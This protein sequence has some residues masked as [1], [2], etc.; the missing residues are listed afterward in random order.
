MAPSV[1]RRH[2]PVNYAKQLLSAIQSIRQQKQIP[3]FDRISRFLQ[4]YTDI[5]PRRCKEHL[6]N[7]V[8][9]GFIV[10]YTALGV[11]GQRTGLEQ[12]GYRSTQDGDEEEQDDGHDWYCF[13][14]H[15]P[16]EVYECSDCFRVYHQGCTREDT[17]GEAFVCSVCRASKKKNKM[18]KKM[19]NTLLSYTILRLREKTRELHKIGLKANAEDFKRF[20][21]RRM[22]LNRMEQKVQASRY[23]CLEEFHADARTILHNCTLVYGDEKGGMTD[24]AVV[25]VKDC[26]Y[27][28]DEIE[29][30]PNCYYM[31]NA[32]PEDWFSQPCNPPHELVYAKQ[33]GYS[34]WPA[35]VVKDLGGKSDVRFFGGWHQRAVIP[36]EYIKP[37]T[38]DLKAMT[39]KRTAGFTKAVKELKRHQEILEERERELEATNGKG[40]DEEEE[41]EE[42][43]EDEEEMGEQ[44]EEAEGEQE[45]G[46]EKHTEESLEEEEEEVIRKHSP[47]KAVRKKRDSY[48]NRSK[49]SQKRKREDVEDEEEEEDDF[50]NR[51]VTSTSVEKNA[52]KRQRNSAKYNSQ[53]ELHTVTSSMDKVANS[54]P[55]PMTTTASQTLSLS[56]EVASVQTDPMVT[57]TEQDKGSST[58]APASGQQS[59]A[60]DSSAMEE[61]MAEAMAQL[62]RR[63][64]EKFEEDKKDALKELSQRLEEDFGKDKQQAVERTIASMKLEVEKARKQGEENT[65]EQYMEEMKKLAAKH[66]EA[67]SQA[68]KQQ[69]CQSCEKEAIYHCCW[70]TSYCSTKCQQVHWHKEHKRVCRRKRPETSSNH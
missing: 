66:K 68:K 13:E 52:R 8:S 3:N 48:E 45:D 6:N 2:T 56:Y 55:V 64:E 40:L 15:S 5:T 4:R 36:A 25:M 27:D 19:L 62:T 59:E 70:N 57:D 43:E 50:E 26:K 69:W 41:E 28:L 38:T 20:V 61:R 18:K 46:S 29:L 67:I 35:K 33:K 63:L 30:C 47:K 58:E 51:E 31:S 12:E 39:I 53:D 42:D 37:I 54:P 16:G 49:K 24:L 14:C 10:E 11:K 23:K 32:K 22:D 65:R 21:Y 44:K 60:A 9:D 34:Y 1:R 7:A 17:T